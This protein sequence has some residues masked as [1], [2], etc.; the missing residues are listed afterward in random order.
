MSRSQAPAAILFDLDGTLLD[1]A[2]DLGAAL[3]KLLAAEQRPQVSAAEYT[4]L[5]SHGSAGLLKYAYGVAEFE[6]RKTELRTA[7]LRA[8]ADSI[9]AGTDLYPGV[10]ELL[11]ELQH[12]S[13]AFAIVTNKPA[14]L[15]E[16]LLPH[17]PLLAAIEVVVCGDTLAVAKPAPDPLFFA[18]QQLGVQAEQCWYIGDAERDIQ[19]GKAAGMFTV[20]AEYGYIH[21]SD[22]PHLWLADQHISSPT[23]LLR[24]LPD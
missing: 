1:T 18:A 22:T 24:I 23:D 2:P 21:Q 8:Y 6:A 7:F 14:K 10:A 9:A 15:T 5:A 11:R 4:P 17:Y 12:R 20:L 13:I 19:A 16:Q 3:N